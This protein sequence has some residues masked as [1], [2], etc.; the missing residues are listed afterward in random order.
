MINMYVNGV[1]QTDSAAACA[2]GDASTVLH[3]GS[4]TGGNYYWPGYLDEIRWSK[5]VARWTSNFTP[6]TSPHSSFST[7]NTDS[8]GNDISKKN[9]QNY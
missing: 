1:K 4:Y 7:F 2:M 5:G 6:P 8:I 3:I 9:D